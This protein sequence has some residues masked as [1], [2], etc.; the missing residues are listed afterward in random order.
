MADKPEPKDERT[1]IQKDRDEELA[2]QEAVRK[3]VNDATRD[4]KGFPK[5]IL[6]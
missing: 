3:A 4:A 1:Q 6:P 5:V 2:R